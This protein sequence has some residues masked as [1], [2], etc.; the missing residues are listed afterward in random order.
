MKKSIRN[1][2]SGG[3]RRSSGRSDELVAKVRKDPAL[4]RE[5]IQAMGDRDPIVRMRAADAAEKI[6][7][8][9]PDLLPPWKKLLLEKIALIPQQEVRWHVAQMLPRLHLSPKKKASAID[10]LT[11]YLKDES[12]IVKTLA[13]QALA[14]LA[15]E[16]AALQV[17]VTRLAEEFIRSGSPAMRSRSRKILASLRKK[18]G[19]PANRRVRAPFLP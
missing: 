7:A 18:S 10:I 6:T 3:D 17:R 12:R 5:V 4:F 1:M 11:V 13:L 16:D 8:G 19:I 2:L 15:E 14:D 9:S